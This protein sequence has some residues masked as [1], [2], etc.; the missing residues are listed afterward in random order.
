MA[1]LIKLS[2]LLEAMQHPEE[3]ECLLD[4]DTGEVIVITEE[5]RDY[6]EEEESEI[7]DL[8]HWQRE[9]VLNARRAIETGRLLPLPD[10]HD[11][12]EWEIMRRFADT[13]DEPMRTELL[14]AVHGTGAFRMFSATNDRLGLR[15]AW[16][17]FKDEALRDIARAW[18]SEHGLAFVDE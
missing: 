5:E 10:K 13:Q 18:L 9:A 17:K 16:F 6:L 7:A 11:V 2:S 1:A 4:P 14:D 15:E 12:H 8:P 3:W